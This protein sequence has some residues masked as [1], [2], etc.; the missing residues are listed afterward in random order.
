[1]TLRLCSA[2]LWL[3]LTSATALASPRSAPSPDDIPLA[4]PASLEEAEPERMTEAS[5]L[6]AP[7]LLGLLT[8]LSASFV[9][10]RRTRRHR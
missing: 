9:Y 3:C 10:A 6:D 7:G 2:L 4:R 8:A 1:M 5:A